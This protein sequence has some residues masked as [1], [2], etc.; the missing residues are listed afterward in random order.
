MPSLLWWGRSDRDYS[1]NRIVMTLLSELGFRIQ[2]FHP[3]SSYTGSMEAHFYN[4]KKPDVIWVPCFRQRDIVSASRWAKKWN[5]PFIV[6]PLISAYEK[7]VFER[8]KWSPDS[9]KAER[10]RLWEAGLFSL[11][12]VIVA[13][14]PAHAEFFTET[15]G[16]AP[17]KLS[18]LYVGAENDFF[19]PAS[20]RKLLL[21]ARLKSF[22]ME[23]FCSFRV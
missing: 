8:N 20:L 13:D 10:R 1:R 19:K 2:Y 7:E 23:A 9:H 3:R 15:L 22:F 17:G 21:P 6:D 12:D 18:V 5:I 16:V 11:A 4:L 14:T